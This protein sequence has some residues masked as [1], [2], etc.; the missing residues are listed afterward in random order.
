MRHP[1]HFAM[2][3]VFA[4]VSAAGQVHEQPAIAAPAMAGRDSI[5]LNAL[6]GSS[7]TIRGSTTVGASWR[8]TARDI[9]ASAILADGATGFSLGAIRQVAVTV[10]VWT[11]KCQSGPMERA[12]RKALRADHDSTSA[13]AGAFSAHRAAN[14]DSAGAH[15][16]GALTVAGVTQRVRLDLSVGAAR[17]GAVAVESIVPL[18]L[19]QFSITPPRVWFGAIR[20]RDRITVEVD[21]RFD[22]R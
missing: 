4:A 11:L 2:G 6:S 15:L 8:C 9:R 19:S 5:A 21:L 22:G 17:D 18:T 7:L 16:D 13:I 3:V 12:M 14:A 20:A 10:P 1:L